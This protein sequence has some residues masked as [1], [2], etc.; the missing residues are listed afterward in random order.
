MIEKNSLTPLEKELVRL[1]ENGDYRDLFFLVVHEKIDPNCIFKTKNAIINIF[2][3]RCAGSLISFLKK[4][5]L[6]LDQHDQSG[7]V[8]LEIATGQRDFSFFKKLLELGANPNIKT[9]EKISILSLVIDY[10]IV[11]K[12]FFGIE[13]VEELLGFEVKYFLS[14]LVAKVFKRRF[15]KIARFLCSLAYFKKRFIF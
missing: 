7:V 12:K 4:Q 3:S 13:F 9:S 5:G 8:L 2:S 14:P 10:T 1:L 6:D 15:K 11:T